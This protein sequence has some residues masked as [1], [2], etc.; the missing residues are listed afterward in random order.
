MKQV[1]LITIFVYAVIAVWYVVPGVRTL[2]K[3][4]ALIALVWVH[5]FRYSVLYLAIAR[6]EG[7]G[8]TDRAAAQIT[9]G[10]LTGAATALL[11]IVILRY[12]FRAGVMVTWLLLVATIVDAAVIFR[13]RAI[14]PPRGDA[15]GPWWFIFC[16]FAPLVMVSVALLIWQ[17]F[18]RRHEPLYERR[19]ANE[20]TV[21]S[22]PGGPVRLTASSV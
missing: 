20:N 3:A 21:D 22:Q 6:R 14:D 12:R 7:Y 17:L 9:I 8:I 19:A 4:Q 1:Q 18:V 5:V 2:T 15:Q 13:Q 11:A 10:D 16:F